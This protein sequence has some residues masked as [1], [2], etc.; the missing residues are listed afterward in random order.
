MRPV[1]GGGISG[2]VGL[3]LAAFGIAVAA[4]IVATE[5]VKFPGGAVP[6]VAL[7]PA[8]SRSCLTAGPYR[9]PEPGSVGLPA[10]MALCASGPI[11]ITEPGAVLDGWDVRGGIVVD[12]PDVVVRRSRI[13]G[14][15]SSPYGIRTTPAGSVRIEDT[16]LTGNFPVAAVG[17]DRWSGTRIEI[18]GVTREGARVGDYARLRGSILRHFE[19]APGTQRDALIVQGSVGDVLV[20]D[21]RIELPRGGGN[22]VRIAPGASGGRGRGMIMIKSNVLGGGTYTVYE[23]SASGGVAEVWITGNRFGRSADE[24]PLRVSSRAVL[25]DNRFADGGALPGR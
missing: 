2:R 1:G 16:L 9:P 24:G 11:T 3:A 17:E 14:D 19:P 13:T 10:G 4:V 25:E 22:A 21:N 7:A 8:A 18:S 20:E 12:A 23:D 6:T 5:G 15:G